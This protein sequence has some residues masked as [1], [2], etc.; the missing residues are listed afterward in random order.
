MN[1]E[2]INTAGMMII[3]IEALSSTTNYLVVAGFQLMMKL[4][5]QARFVC[6]L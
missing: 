3:K 4:V 5:K 6:L 2:V 1:D